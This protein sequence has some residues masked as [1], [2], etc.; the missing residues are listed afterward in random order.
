[1]SQI[2]SISVRCSGAGIQYRNNLLFSLFLSYIYYLVIS[3]SLTATEVSGGNIVTNLPFS[4]VFIPNTTESAADFSAAWLVHKSHLIKI[5]DRIN[6]SFNM[7]GATFAVTRAKYEGTV[8]VMTRDYF[9]FMVEHLSAT[10]NQ[11]PFSNPDIFEAAHDKL[12]GTVKALASHVATFNETF[13]DRMDPRVYKT[14]AIMVYSSM[15]FSARHSTVQSRIRKP[16]FEATFWSVYRYFP[17]TI[18]FVADD[19]DAAAVRDMNIPY[20]RLV[21]MPVPLDH[22]NRSTALPRYSII[23]VIK[24]MRQG[25]DYHGMDYVYFTEGDQILHMRRAG[26]LFDTIDNSDG[27][28]VVAPHRMQVSE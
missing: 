7:A 24:H 5:E 14:V 27:Y 12:A 22:L 17:N 25:T 16:F 2:E 3:L 10:S 15:A 21:K 23:S 13:N 28:F 18:V 26:D 11:I 19:K 1:M 4:G 9:D 8:T 20:W 6:A